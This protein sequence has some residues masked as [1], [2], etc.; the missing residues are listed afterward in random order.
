MKIAII[1]SGAMGS[2]YGGFLSNAGYKVYLLDVWQEHVDRINNNGLIISEQDKDIKAY[3]KATSKACEIGEVDL[4]VVFVKS[5]ATSEALNCS[6]AVI[7]KNTIVLSL[8]NGYGNIEEIEKTVERDNIIA[9]TTAHGATMLGSGHIRHAGHG[10]THIGAVSGKISGKVIDTAEALRRAGFDTDLSR[11]VMKLIWNKLIVNV[12][13]NA[14]TAIVNV[15]NGELALSEETRLL[16]GEAVSEAVAVAKALGMDFE[17]TD[18][19]NQVIQ[20]AEKT[21][22]NLSSMLQDVRK[23]RRTEIDYINGAIVK[24]GKKANINTPVNFVL[25]NLVKA[26]ENKRISDNLT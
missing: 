6:K 11:D 24:E 7:G 13:I 17:K 14:L 26:I 3:P 25:T 23:G 4:A 18:A 8:Q 15:K 9:G 19:I 16:M 12:G 21:S 1:G 2:L 22:E 5:T 10:I 20:V